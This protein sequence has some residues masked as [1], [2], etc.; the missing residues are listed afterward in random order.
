MKTWQEVVP[1]LG[2]TSCLQVPALNFCLESLSEG[3]M[4]YAIE[5]KDENNPF[6][7]DLPFVMVFWNSIRNSKK[8]IVLKVKIY[9]L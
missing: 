6:F 9:G 3:A 1:L 5:V 7:S 4:D 2:I 8:D